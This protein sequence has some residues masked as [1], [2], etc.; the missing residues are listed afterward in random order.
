MKNSSLPENELLPL[1]QKFLTQYKEGFSLLLDQCPTI[2]L[3][4]YDRSLA[5]NLSN[6]LLKGGFHLET[7]EEGGNLCLV[8]NMNKWVKAGV[9]VLIQHAAS[10]TEGVSLIDILKATRK[11]NPHASFSHIIPIMNFS[12][13]VQRQQELLKILGSFA[14]EQVIFLTPDAPL[15]TILDEVTKELVYYAKRLNRI[16][17]G[18]REDKAYRAKIGEKAEQ[19]AERSLKADK[20]FDS[21]LQRGSECMKNGRYEEAIEILTKAIDIKPEFETLIQRGDSYYAIREFIDALYDYRKAHDIEKKLPLPYTNIS[22]CCFSLIKEE[23]QKEGKEQAEKWLALATSC[24]NNARLLIDAHRN[25]LPDS[26]EASGKSPYQDLVEILADTDIR[27]YH[28]KG[29]EEM[30]EVIGKIIESSNDLDFTSSNYDIDSRIDQAILLTRFKQY[31]KAEQILRELIAI[32]SELVCPVFNNFAI[33]LRKNGK[34]AKAFSIYRELLDLG[35][36]PDYA[37]VLENYRRTGLVYAQNLRRE[38][39]HEDAIRIYKQILKART[40]EKEWVLCE[41]AAAYMEMEL[42][43]EASLRLVEAVFV[44]SKLTDDE[45]FTPYRNLSTL[46]K[47]IIERLKSLPKR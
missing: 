33:E 7:T 18:N 16:K 42:E 5:L 26:Y 46:S 30:H 24:L 35:D 17:T 47:R 37:I 39:R 28:L 8:R 3:S 19:D 20:H 43:T 14:I 40:K 10:A 21:L 13:G 25:R 34:D 31:E 11:G 32:D 41:L 12:Y 1:V 45:K 29:E 15:E 2:A 4:C 9:P 22:R 23:M 38:F 44:N 36:I 27:E 6:M